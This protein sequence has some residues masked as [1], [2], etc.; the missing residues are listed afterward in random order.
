VSVQ[1]VIGYQGI[2]K[3]EERKGKALDFRMARRQGKRKQKKKRRDI[4][5]VPEERLGDLIE[6]ALE[7][8]ASACRM[9]TFV[10]WCAFVPRDLDEVGRRP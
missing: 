7:G 4:S 5:D 8:T 9:L 10:K 3:R 2:E 6:T 1:A